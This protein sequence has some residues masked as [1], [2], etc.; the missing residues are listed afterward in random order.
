MDKEIE[1]L[2]DEELDLLRENFYKTRNLGLNH[3]K[4]KEKTIFS[5]TDEELKAFKKNPV[6]MSDFSD[7]YKPLNDELNGDENYESYVMPDG[8]INEKYQQKKSL[9][10]ILNPTIDDEVPYYKIPAAIRYDAWEKIIFGWIVFVI[11]LITYAL[12]F[13]EYPM[14]IFGIFFAGLLTT[15][16]VKKIVAGKFNRYVKFEG[17]IV[18][19]EVYGIT[20]SNQYMIVKMSDGEKFLNIKMKLSKDVK[21]GL[22]ITVYLPPDLLI[23]PSRFGPLAE[24]I[25][26]YKLD[27][28]TEATDE[29][30]AEGTISA[31]EYIRHDPISGEIREKPKQESIAAYEN[32]EPMESISG[33]K[34]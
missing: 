20:K 13:V 1:N 30:L 24:Y 32:T 10:F 11:I 27:V 17:I 25:I 15:M 16:G 31:D 23:V 26:A 9:E 34:H 19:S 18:D 2:T 21:S 5:F 6:L 28:S 33:E 22:P 4:A 7:L 12:A 8:S 3:M 29:L 14:L